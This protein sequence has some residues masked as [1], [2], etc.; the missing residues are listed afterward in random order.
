MV[1][2]GEK[3]GTF[4]AFRDGMEIYGRAVASRDR[5]LVSVEGWSHYE[6]YDK[7]EPVGVAL[8]NLV[9]FFE[10][11]LNGEGNRIERQAAE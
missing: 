4:G 11:H 8:E 2:I 5:Q 6:L 3:V 9:P 1:V 7:P 10:K